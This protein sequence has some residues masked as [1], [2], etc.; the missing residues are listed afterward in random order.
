MNFTPSLRRDTAGNEHT[1]LLK[2]LAVLFM[3]VDHAGGVLFPSLRILRYI[4]RLS[5][6]LFAWGLVVGSCKSRNLYQYALR[7]MI[8][9]VLSQPLYMLALN[10]SLSQ[11]NIFGTLLL[12]LAGIICIREKW[13]YSHLWGPFI[14]LLV[15]YLFSRFLHIQFDYG[16]QGVAFILLLYIG[17]K[18][19][20]TLAASFLLMCLIWWQ[21]QAFWMW[22]K[23]QISNFST[24]PRVYVGKIQPYAILALPLI[25]CPMQSNFR[26]PKWLS[27]AI[28][29]LHLI[30]LYWL[31]HLL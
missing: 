19:S 28:Y 6:P 22:F 27:Y 7:L 5:F 29:P 2:L 23:M 9:G 3:L 10:H 25:L 12:G 20:V 21:G 14:V 30:I 8:T 11:I 15:C 31:D 1:A 16:L 18:R 26:M 17:R 24:L 13:H 4:G